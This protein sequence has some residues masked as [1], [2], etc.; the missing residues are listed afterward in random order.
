MPTYNLNFFDLSYASTDDPDGFSDNGGYQFNWGVSTITI[1]PGA[2][3]TPV[4]V[5]DVDTYFDD[6]QDA[7]QVLNGPA[8]LNG[9]SYPDGTWIQAE[10]I[11]TVQDSDGRS[12]TLQFVSVGTDA[13][14]IQGFV[15][16][17]AVPPFGEPLT[18][19]STADSVQGV[20]SYS[21]SSPAC[22]APR[23]RIATPTGHIRAKNLKRGDDIRL[24]DGRTARVALI[25]TSSGAE[26]A[27]IRIRKDAFGRGLPR[28]DL[29]LSPQHRV[30]MPQLGAL[31]PARALTC[32]PRVGLDRDATGTELIHIVLAHHEVL[33]AEG[34][35]CESYWPGDTALGLL[36]RA[37]RR[38]VRKIMGRATP[39]MPFMRVKEAIRRLTCAAGADPRADTPRHA[40]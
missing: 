12:Y 26:D 27:P 40:A 30:W 28:R 31:V 11:V 14:N 21:T 23:S 36:P 38:E 13:F 8:T 2:T 34:L 10:Y 33:L 19:V 29:T 17:G 37:S 18:V 32:L 22:F 6:D 20:H 9:V 4:S 25:L 7:A 1:A 5:Q 16:Q 24:A 3:E 35:P 39:A 15:V